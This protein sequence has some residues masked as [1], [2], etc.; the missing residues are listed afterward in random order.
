MRIEWECDGEKGGFPCCD[1]AFCAGLRLSLK[2]HAVV[3]MVDVFEELEAETQAFLGIEC[4]M[5]EQ[6]LTNNAVLHVCILSSDIPVL[7]EITHKY[8]GKIYAEITVAGM[9]IAVVNDFRAE[10]VEG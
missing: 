6:I 10:Q 1:G 4:H 5:V 3:S 8:A 7:R 2:G 9:R